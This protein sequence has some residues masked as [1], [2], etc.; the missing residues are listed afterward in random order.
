MNEI[1]GFVAFL[2][3]LG[4]RRAVSDAS[5]ASD[6]KEYMSAV[7]RAIAQAD[8]RPSSR[9]GRDLRL[10]KAGPRHAGATRN[11]WPEADIPALPVSTR[12]FRGQPPHGR[13]VRRVYAADPYA[14]FPQ[15]NPQTKAP[16]SNGPSDD[17]TLTR[18]MILCDRQIFSRS[19]PSLRLTAI[20]AYC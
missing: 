3:V 1:R 12:S 10:D 19:T 15:R 13:L 16:I 4:F 2:D 7:Q 11:P 9:T 6:L 14:E 5:S 17:G 20:Y 18:S 8:A